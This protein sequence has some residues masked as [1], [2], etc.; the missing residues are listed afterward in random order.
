MRTLSILLL[1]ACTGRSEFPACEGD[2]PP[3]ITVNLTDP[4]GA[5]I[6]EAQVSYLYDSYDPGECAAVGAPATVF[7][8]DDD[9]AGVYEI[10][11]T[12]YGF[13]DATVA[14]EVS[15]DG[16]FV[17]TE[18]VDL[19]LQPID[20]PDRSPVSVTVT[21]VT[22]QGSAVP[23]AAVHYLPASEAW[24]EPRPCDGVQPQ[25]FHCGEGFVGEI[26]LLSGGTETTTDERTV[27]V[28]EDA[29]GPIPAEA[30]VVLRPA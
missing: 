29:C 17:R 15:G 18:P 19:V 9:R 7:T 5:P 25:V 1:A 3:A 10:T 21:V 20:C 27:T 8:C 23:G 24:E 12:G 4:D 16:C 30:T 2:P 26:L 13:Q 6:P 28:R 22:A 14:A 11:A